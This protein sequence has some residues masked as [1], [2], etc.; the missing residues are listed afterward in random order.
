MQSFLN[1]LIHL[2]NGGRA[3]ALILYGADLE[4][5]YVLFQLNVDGVTSKVS[6]TLPVPPATL[7]PALGIWDIVITR[8]VKL[9]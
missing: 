2:S 3:L 4:R 7:E 6:R 5:Q 8:K 1:V 9:V